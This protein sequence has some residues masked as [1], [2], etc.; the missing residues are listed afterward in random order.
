ME[1]RNGDEEEPVC[2]QSYL[3]DMS[4]FHCKM[5]SPL[6][7]KYGLHENQVKQWV[8]YFIFSSFVHLKTYLSSV[9]RKRVN[10]RLFLYVTTVSVWT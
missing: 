3:A 2:S 9:V 1:E 10:R 5:I 4:Y 6:L 7:I 8:D